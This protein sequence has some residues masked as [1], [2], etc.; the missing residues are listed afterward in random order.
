MAAMTV[1]PTKL[2]AAAV[3]LAI[4]A[5]AGCEAPAPAVQRPTGPS[6]LA[7]WGVVVVGADATTSDGAPTPIFDNA[8]RD[9]AQA[10]LGVGFSHASLAQL[11]VNP[12]GEPGVAETTPQAFTA[13]AQQATAQSTGCLFYLT[14]HGSQQGLTFGRYARLDPQTLGSLVSGW[15]GQRPTVVIV[16]ACFSGVFVPAL[17]APNRMVMT[18]ARGDRSSFGCG[19]TDRYPYFDA[20][21]LTSLPRSVNLLH[22]ADEVRACVTRREGETGSSPPSEPQV[23]IGDQ[24]RPVLAALPFTNAGVGA[25]PPPAS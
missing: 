24:V 6:P 14:S 7:Q 15:C 23:L 17:A 4:L 22:L 18:A 20:C 10:L 13:L 9:V 21:V 16:S 11:S 1:T 3:A 5:L 12:N 25:G 2:A 19:G 8:R